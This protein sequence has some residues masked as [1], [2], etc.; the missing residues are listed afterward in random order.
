[1]AL[2]QVLASLSVVR[3]SAGPLQREQA[4][5]LQFFVVGPI[6]IK[7]CFEVFKLAN[8]QSHLLQTFQGPL[9]VHVTNWGFTGWQAVNTVELHVQVDR[10]RLVPI[11]N[12]E[13]RSRAL[14]GPPVVLEAFKSPPQVGSGAW[15]GSVCQHNGRLAEN[16][17]LRRVLD[18]VVSLL[19]LDPQ[20]LGQPVELLPHH[21][22]RGGA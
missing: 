20:S 5:S 18:Q 1:V 16:E 7:N 19:G 4:A 14:F 22:A 12:A 3:S 21:P 6:Q 15:F 17:L 2:L 13:V 10:V 11:S 8:L 9:E